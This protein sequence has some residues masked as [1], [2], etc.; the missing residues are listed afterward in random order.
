MFRENTNFLG[1]EPTLY[2]PKSRGFIEKGSV[3]YNKE[4]P[5]LWVMRNIKRLK[6]SDGGL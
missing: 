4:T 3:N 6:S 5:S 2:K 1:L